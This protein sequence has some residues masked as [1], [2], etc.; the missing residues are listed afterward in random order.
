MLDSPGA[1]ESE[2]KG[3]GLVGLGG[4]VGERMLG[5]PGA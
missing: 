3:V 4:R 5:S 1:R 2:R